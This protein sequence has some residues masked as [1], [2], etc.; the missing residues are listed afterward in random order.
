MYTVPLIIITVFAFALSYL[1]QIVKKCTGAAA[2][3]RRWQHGSIL[4]RLS[5]AETL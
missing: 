3:L 1:Q 2:Q 5:T 4:L